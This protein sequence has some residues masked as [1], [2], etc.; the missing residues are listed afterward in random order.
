VISGGAEIVNDG[1]TVTGTVIGSGGSQRLSGY[2]IASIE[3]PFSTILVSAVATSTTVNSGGAQVVSALATTISTT[4]SSGGIEIVSSGGTASGSTILTGGALLLLAGATATGTT[5]SGQVI[6]SGVVE[7]AGYALVSSGTGST[8]TGTSVTSGENEIV[9]V[10]GTVISALVSSGG[11]VT[12]SKG[13]GASGD[14]VTS[15][16]S[17]HRQLHHAQCQRHANGQFRRLR[18][19]RG[20]RQRRHPNS[21]QRWYRQCDNC[22]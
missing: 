21:R 15:A 14:I 20:G 18:G 12:I 1:G 2:S 10:G 9:L 17:E 6:S 22:G 16:G 11:K 8:I 19:G 4:V 5:G 13:G 3:Y 7:L